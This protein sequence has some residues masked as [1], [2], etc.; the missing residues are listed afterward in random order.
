MTL[1]PETKMM[2]RVILLSITT[3]EYGG[4]FLLRVLSGKEERLALTPFQKSMFRA[5]H[6]HAGVLVILSLLA[7][8]LIDAARSS[9]AMRWALRAGFGISPLMVSGG[10]F[11]A[12]AGKGRTKPNKMIT[13]LIAGMILLGVSLIGLGIILINY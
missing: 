3:I 10:F 12:A 9:E 4:Y 11:A 13:L 7:M 2:C 1:S 5:G 6:A 8:L